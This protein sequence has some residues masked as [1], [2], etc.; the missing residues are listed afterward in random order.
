MKKN[1]LFLLLISLVFGFTIESK[2]QAPTRFSKHPDKFLEE[3]ILFF[4]DVN[5]K[6]KKDS[7]KFMEFFIEEWTSG[8][9]SIE[10]QEK[11]YSTS[12]L[13][14]KRKMRA[15]PHFFNYLT[16]VISFINSG[17]S[18]GNFE[19]WQTSLVKT[20]TQGN[21]RQYLSYLE[22]SNNLFRIFQEL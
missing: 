22:I 21:S 8:K 1:Y 17:Q 6:D 10:Q 16:T 4:E 14:L 15:F 3:M 9:F 5:K 11:I 13:M 18:A 12:N 2:A 19:T 20:L 7:K